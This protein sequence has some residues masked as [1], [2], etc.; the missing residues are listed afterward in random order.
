[1]DQKVTIMLDPE[2]GNV[3]KGKPC[4]SLIVGCTDL[5]VLARAQ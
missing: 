3:W 4:I 1:M 5:E 2:L